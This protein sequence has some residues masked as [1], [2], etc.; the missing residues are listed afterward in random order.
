[1][2]AIRGGCLCGAVRYEA[3]GEPMISGA[4]HC[5]DCQYVSGG[6]PA[7]TMVLPR[8]AVKVTKGTPQIFWS[9]SQR[10]NRVGRSFCAACGTP[11]FG[12]RAD[13]PYIAVKSGSLD[14]PASFK[15][16]GHI[17]VSSAPPWH[18]IDPALPRWD[19][20]PG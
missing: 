1:M 4:C 13:Q 15:P 12:E 9:Q 10:G 6:A 16:Q 2:K 11:L 3:D 7:F 20:D 8:N 19:R 17:W 18:A 5:R 14:D